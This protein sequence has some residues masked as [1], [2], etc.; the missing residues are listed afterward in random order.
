M[1]GYDEQAGDEY[2][3]DDPA[4]SFEPDLVCALGAGVRHTVNQALAQTIRP[5][6]HHLI[7]FAEQ[8]RWVAPLGVQALTELSLSSGSQTL[9]QSVN[10]HAADFESLIRSMARDHDYSAT[11]S[12]KSKSKANLASS[13]SD[14]PSDQGDDSPVGAQ[15]NR[16]TRRS[17]FLRLKSLRLNRR[18]LC[19]PD[20]PYGCPQRRWQTMWNPTLGMD[21]KRRFD[22]DCVLSDPDQISPLK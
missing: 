3:V 13:S 6:K 4:G 2:Y 18:T 15:R 9:K 1:A 8:Q 19:I 17:L 21:L 22:P 16:T 5:I 10:L 7:G 20:L 11:S 12:Q 14:H